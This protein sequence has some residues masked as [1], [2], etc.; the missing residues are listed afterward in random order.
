MR[1]RLYCIMLDIV[2]FET[3]SFDRVRF[4]FTSTEPCTHRC[5]RGRLS[6]FAS[7]VPSVRPDNSAAT[8]SS[9]IAG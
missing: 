5:W 8:G 2:A 7:P 4:V 3:V 6:A 9:G 1:L